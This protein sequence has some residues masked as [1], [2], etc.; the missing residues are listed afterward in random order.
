MA[1]LIFHLGFLIELSVCS[2]VIAT[3]CEKDFVV[4][5]CRLVEIVSRTVFLS[6]PPGASEF[7][8][9]LLLARPKILESLFCYCCLNDSSK[10]FM[11]LLFSGKS[12]TL[13][14]LCDWRSHWTKE[15]S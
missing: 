3:E 14:F 5:Q 12:Y 15:P 13:S 8:K 10:N 9:S 4:F 2:Q 6:K 11:S 7:L 1:M